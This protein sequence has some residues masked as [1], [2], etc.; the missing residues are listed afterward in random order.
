MKLHEVVAVEPDLKKK[1]EEREAEAVVTFTK[2]DAHFEGYRKVYTSATDDGENL[3]ADIK[4]ITETV[5]K[6]LD[7]VLSYVIKAVDM[8]ATKE[9]TNTVAKADIVIDGTVVATGVPATVIINLENKMKRLRNLFAA[10]PTLDPTEVW[11]KKEDGTYETTPV[12]QDR[13]VKYPEYIT[14]APATQ[15]HAAQVKEVMKSRKEGVWETTKVASKITPLEKA[16]ILHRLDVIVQALKQARE[17]ANDI[18]IEKLNIGQQ[19]MTYILGRE[20][21]EVF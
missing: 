17:R 1:A 19:L 2:K 3:P 13:M 15:Q 7:Y 21:K 6:K 5:D 14:V 11:K 4:Q 10:I 8:S 12:T 20:V 9:K 18:D 16:G